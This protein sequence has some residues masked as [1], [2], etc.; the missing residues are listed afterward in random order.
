MLCDGPCWQLM[1]LML[2]EMGHFALCSQLSLG[3]SC[4]ALAIGAEACWACCT[5]TWRQGEAEESQ[6]HG[7][8]MAGKDLSH[9]QA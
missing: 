6:N 2:W 5:Q 8:I 4:P 7:I 3:E 1:A 9:P